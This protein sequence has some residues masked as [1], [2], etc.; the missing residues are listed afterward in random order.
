[1]W[2]LQTSGW[3]STNCTCVL[4]KPTAAVGLATFHTALCSQHGAGQAGTPAVEV[5]DVFA[6]YRR[7]VSETQTVWASL[8]SKSFA[9]AAGL[10]RQ[11]TIS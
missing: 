6:L 1:M 2:N 11:V 4:A 3:V 9:L 7:K 5:P 8:P 10:T